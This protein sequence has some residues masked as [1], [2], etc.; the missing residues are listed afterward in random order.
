MSVVKRGFARITVAARGAAAVALVVSSLQAAGAADLRSGVPTRLDE[1]LCVADNNHLLDGAASPL[2][3]ARGSGT[4]FDIICLD[5]AP[6][7]TD[8]T[9]YPSISEPI[10]PHT[11]GTAKPANGPKPARLSGNTPGSVALLLGGGAVSLGIWEILSIGGGGF[12]KG[13]VPQTTAA[14][15]VDKTDPHSHIETDPN[16]SGAWL[17]ADNRDEVSQTLDPLPVTPEP[18]SLALLAAA[19]LPLLGLRRRRG[20]SARL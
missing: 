2:S 4:P 14:V 6:G 18:S 20:P 9:L 7:D 13:N 16:G 1:P 8:S 5:R 11:T 19:G 10:D 3:T 12:D 15:T 17:V